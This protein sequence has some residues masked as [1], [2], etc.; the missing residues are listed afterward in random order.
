M[1]TRG[2]ASLTVR[3][4]PSIHER[5]QKAANRAGVTKAAWLHE[6]ILMALEVDEGVGHVPAAIQE[7]MPRVV[8]GRVFYPPGRVFDRR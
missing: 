8:N 6:A 4:E 5:V 7:A 3:A 1:T 2:N